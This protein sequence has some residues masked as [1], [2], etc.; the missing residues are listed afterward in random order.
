MK[1][2]GKADH[3]TANSMKKAPRLIGTPKGCA[4][5]YDD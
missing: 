5:Y 1:E 2:T 4:A 3:V